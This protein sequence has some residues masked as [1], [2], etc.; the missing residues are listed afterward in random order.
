MLIFAPEITYVPNT[1]RIDNTTVGVMPLRAIGDQARRGGLRNADT[2]TVGAHGIAEPYGYPDGKIG[3]LIIE[4]PFPYKN[5][6]PVWN[7]GHGSD[8][9]D[10]YGLIFAPGK[11][12]AGGACP[13]V[14]ADSPFA[15]SAAVKPVPLR[16]NCALGCNMTEVSATGVDPCHVGS[17]TPAEGTSNSVM[18]CFDIGSMAGGWGVCGYNCTAFAGYPNACTAKN[19]AHCS[20]YCDTRNYPK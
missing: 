20:I 17:V 13:P 11:P 2:A 19:V 8:L 5:G 15:G 1:A 14:P 16:N 4:G 12:G 6:P 9:W 7:G 3:G 18:S 10:A